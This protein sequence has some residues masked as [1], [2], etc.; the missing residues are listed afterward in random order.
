M[1]AHVVGYEANGRN[2]LE[3]LANSSLM[4]THHE[5]VDRLKNEILELK[6]PGDNVVTTIGD[7]WKRHR[8]ITAPSFSH[9][10]YRNVWDTTVSV[11]ADMLD[12]EGWKD[13][14]ETPLTD[15]NKATHKVCNMFIKCR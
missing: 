2:G 1:F 10:T 13:V 12:K 4:S 8:R 14:G 6:N 9:S 3:S 5:Y 15:I 7:T 11:Y